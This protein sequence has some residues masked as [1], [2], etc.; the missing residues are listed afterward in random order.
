M[1][2]VWSAIAI[3]FEPLGLLADAGRGLDI[4][5]DVLTPNWAFLKQTVEPFIETFQM[6][7]IAAIVGCAIGRRGLWCRAPVLVCVCE[8][9][10]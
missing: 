3:G 5:L 1:L 9:E 6:A 2:T 4:V 10:V 7:V 8:F